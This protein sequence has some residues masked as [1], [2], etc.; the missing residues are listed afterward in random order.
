[1]YS[2][3]SKALNIPQGFE[4]WVIMLWQVLCLVKLSIFMENIIKY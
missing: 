3:D 1:M 4:R 2:G